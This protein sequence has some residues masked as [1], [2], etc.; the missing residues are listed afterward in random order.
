MDQLIGRPFYGDQIPVQYRLQVPLQ[1]AA[2]DG[3]AERL[4]I[5]AGPPAVLVETTQRLPL[6]SFRPC[7]F[8]GTSRRMTCS[9]T[10]PLN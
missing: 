8:T 10:G 6:L 5:L 2:V 7:C 4:E 9:S 3:R 1:V